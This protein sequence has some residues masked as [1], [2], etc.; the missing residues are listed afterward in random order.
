MNKQT[1]CLIYLLGYLK[2]RFALWMLDWLQEKLPCW[3][4]CLLA[5]RFWSS[6]GTSSWE[7]V[8]WNCHNWLFLGACVESQ[9]TILDGICSFRLIVIRECGIMI[10]GHRYASNILA[11]WTWW[12]A[13]AYTGVSYNAKCKAYL[14]VVLQTCHG[15]LIWWYFRYPMIKDGYIA[16]TET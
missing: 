2:S 10:D 8:D 6:I 13:S 14:H 3:L 12:R 7:S 15:S 1:I 4:P 5:T 16:M 11:T 9:R